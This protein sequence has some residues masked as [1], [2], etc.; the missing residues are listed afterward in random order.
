MKGRS[1]VL[2]P[3]DL[4]GGT[5][6]LLNTNP[7]SPLTLNNLTQ[8]S[9][10]IFNKGF[11]TRYLLSSAITS[12]NRDL[13]IIH[14]VVIKPVL[15]KLG[16]DTTPSKKILDMSNTANIGRIARTGTITR[17]LPFFSH[18]KLHIRNDRCNRLQIFQRIPS[19]LI[20][21]TLSD[22]VIQDTQTEMPTI[23]TIGKLNI[24]FESFCQ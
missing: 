22:S 16:K 12:G 17:N 14:P 24:F 3:C 5:T 9:P 2:I 6:V 18:K 7:L 10:A 4:I 1:L 8:I 21:I 23:L 19:G 13:T 15:P 20:E 11:D